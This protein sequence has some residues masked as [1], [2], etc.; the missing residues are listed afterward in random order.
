MAGWKHHA[1]LCRIVAGVAVG[2]TLACG[3]VRAQELS[4]YFPEGVPG[5]G[6]APGVTVASRARPDFDPAGI[7]IDSFL[8]HPQLDEGLGYDSNVFGGQPSAEAGLL[9]RI[10]HCWW[11]RL[12]TQQSWVL[13]SRLMTS[14]IWIAQAELR[15]NWTASLGGSV[16]VGRDQLTLVGVAFRLASTTDRP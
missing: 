3:S 2:C 13:I 8:L 16:A 14:T 4:T 10:L 6:D 7:R 1:Q 12:V 15:P 11:L 5:Y 9:V